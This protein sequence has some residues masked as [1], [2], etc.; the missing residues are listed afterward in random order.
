MILRERKYSYLH[1]MHFNLVNIA[2]HC[3]I[4][5]SS[6]PPTKSLANAGHVFSNG[7]QHGFIPKGRVDFILVYP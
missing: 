4:R 1:H 5:Q 6:S 7:S 2:L 3:C